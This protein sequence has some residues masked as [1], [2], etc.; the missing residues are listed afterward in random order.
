MLKRNSGFTLIE[1]LITSVVISVIALA[2]YSGLSAGIRIWQRINQ[3]SEYEDLAFFLDRFGGDLRSCF[4]FSGIDFS[5]AKDRVSFACLLNSPRLRKTTVGELNYIYE[6]GEG[7][8]LRR[9]MDYSHIY[10]QDEGLIKEALTGVKS[11]EFRFYV[12]DEDQKKYFWLEE[13]D[14]DDLPLAV[15]V[16][17]ELN[18]GWEKVVRTFNIP[19]KQA[20]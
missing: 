17:L 4:K 1:L 2:A 8:L 20:F 15:R 18:G 12:Y 16:E 5:G 19:L 14:R 3:K 13:F 6:A 10:S 11:L 7:K 9:E